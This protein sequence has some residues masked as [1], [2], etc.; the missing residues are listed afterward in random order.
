MSEGNNSK[1]KQKLEAETG[2]E[3]PNTKKLE[4]KAKIDKEKLKVE[5]EMHKFLTIFEQVLHEIEKKK[6]RK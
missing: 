4:R 2:Q 5:A 1:R 3:Q 6:K